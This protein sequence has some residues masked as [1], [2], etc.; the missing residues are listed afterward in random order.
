MSS[1]ARGRSTSKA[2]VEGITPFGLWLLAAG[3]EHFLPFSEFPFFRRAAV[4]DV[5]QVELSGQDHVYWPSLDVDLDVESI[6][7][8]ERF[9]LVARSP[10]PGQ[11]RPV[12]RR[13]PARTRRP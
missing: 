13:A 5:L 2:S 11:G 10:G 7:H 6:L 9:P 8:P 4:E 1:A 3:R 12:R